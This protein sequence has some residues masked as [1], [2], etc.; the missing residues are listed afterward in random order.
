MSFYADLHLHSKY[1]IATSK[2]CNLE[3]FDLWARK[4]GITVLGTGDALHPDWQRE[5]KEKLILCDNGF[6]RLNEKFLHPDYSLY[7]GKEVYFIPT[8][9][10][11]CI[12]KWNG[13]VKRI[14]H[15][16]VMPSLTLAAEMEKKLQKYGNLAVDGRPCLKIDSRELLEIV[17]S[18][19]KKNLLI[20]AHIWTPW[21]S[22]LGSKSG[23]DSIVECFRDL[24]DQIYAVE[25]GLSSDP[26]M[27]RKVAFLNNYTLVSNSDA[28]SPECIGREAT[29]FN[30]SPDLN[31][32]INA[33]K[34]G[35]K[36][37]GY[38]GT[39]EFFP[40]EGKYFLDG[41]RKCKYFQ[42]HSNMS[43]PFN[44]CPECGKKLTPG[45]KSRIDQMRG[46]EC[47][48]SSTEIPPFQKVTPM[49]NILGQIF[50]ISPKSK[51]VTAEYEKYVSTLGTELEML[52]TIP[53]ENIQ[54][55]SSEL[56]EYIKNMRSGNIN[57][58]PGYDGMFGS[59]SININP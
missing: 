48:K 21:Y 8:T 28:H 24:S 54:K 9:E 37:F 18:I 50:N 25:T 39:I 53:I 58:L 6:Y 22:I 20:P 3:M 40:E 44:V 10:V 29:Y 31:S 45:V 17:I 52:V 36:K 5:L 38:N 57:I 51:K 59:I 27:N 41:H 1:S 23:F 12:Y 15:L 46:R 4:K 55:K 49:K 19:S 26:S 56:A 13:K 30:L 11:N 14:H 42:E 34:Q 32:L 7:F 2:H 16:L 47:F 33:I 35:K 43:S